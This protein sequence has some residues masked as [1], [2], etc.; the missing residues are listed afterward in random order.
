MTELVLKTADKAKVAVDTDDATRVA[1]RLGLAFFGGAL[2][3]VGVASR[4]AGIYV[5]AVAD[6]AAAIGALAL[7]A[8]IVLRAA[9]NVR[10][11]TLDLDELIALAIIAAF[12]FEDYV[13]AGAVAFFATLG[14]LVERRTA[15]GARAAIESLVRLT[16]TRAKLVRPDGTEVEVEATSLR[17]GDLVRV[18][19]GDFVPADGTIRSGRSTLDEKSIT[20]E[21]QPA[22]KGPEDA[23]FAGTT[24][25]T[26]SLDVVVARAGEDTTLGRVKELILAAERARPPVARLIDRTVASYLPFV[27]MVAALVLFFT[28]EPSRFVAVLVVACPTAL[29]LATPTAMVAAL[30]C[31]ARLG[32]LIKDARDLEVAGKLSQVVFDKTGTLTTGQ[33]GVSRLVPVAGE[34]AGT[35]LLLAASVARRSNHPASRAVVAVAREAELPLGDAESFEEVSGKGVSGV[36]QGKRVLL[37]RA[38]LLQENGVALAAIP[39]ELEGLSVL[40]FAVEGRE[41]ACFGLEDRTRH[42]AKAAVAD[43]KSLGVRRVVMLTGD[44]WIV[45]R[46]V[47]RD[48]GC[49]DVAAECLPAQ[50]L[51]LVEAARKAGERVAVVGDGVNDA[52]ALAAGDLGIAMGAAG[53]DVAIGSARVALL[54]DDLTRLPFLVRLSRQTRAIVAQNLV[55]GVVLIASGLALA[56]AGRLSPILAIVLHNLGSLL[57]VFNSA[58]LVRAGEELA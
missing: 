44:R 45:A 43:L 36:V 25:V 26:G 30:S 9:R 46:R 13:T 56:G 31:A 28:R 19:P 21:S 32:I 14:E 5:P 39:P 38:T 37:G 10:D 15:L 51:E 27:V 35:V 42:D 17:A 23:V 4:S 50:K 11:G 33:L 22:E 49:D 7:A 29:V 48:L 12:A 40:H 6:G 1:R 16:P 41:V 2:V 24:N 52:P 58:R 18:R 34:D 57:V 47:A 55:A 54:N 8:P 53:S 20:G 3:L